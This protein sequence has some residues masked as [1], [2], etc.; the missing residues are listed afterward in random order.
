MTEPTTGSDTTQLKTRAVR[1]GD[2][3]VVNGQKLW[4]SRAHNPT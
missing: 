2:H 4:T 3:Y 1:V